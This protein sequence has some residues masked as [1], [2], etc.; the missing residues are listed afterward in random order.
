MSAL[1]RHGAYQSLSLLAVSRDAHFSQILAVEAYDFMPFPHPSATRALLL[2]LSIQ[3]SKSSEY[4]KALKP[5]VTEIKARYKGNE[6][7]QNRAVGK[8]YEDANQNPLSGCLLSLAQ[9]PIFL[10]LY[11]G[12]R[13]LALDGALEEPFLFIPSLEGPVSPPTYRGLDWLLQGWTSI[14]NMPTPQLGWETTLA[15]LTMP[16]LLVVLQSFTMS[17]LQPPVDQEATDEEKKQQETTQTVLK[18]LPLMIGFFSLQVP[19]GLTIYWLSSNLFTLTQSLAVKTYFAANPPE[20]ELPEYWDQMSEKKDFKD[21][22]PEERRKATE[23]GLSVGPSFED[24]VNESKFHVYVERQPFRETTEAWQRVESSGLSEIPLA[25][26]EWVA[27][28]A[29]TNGVD[30]NGIDPADEGEVTA[31][32][33]AESATVTAQSSQ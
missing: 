18:V 5:Y 10:G 2:P 32:D 20:I 25:M 30:A 7:A 23:A 3:Q 29:T 6:E 1:I 22:S 15:F 9:I 4:M 28:S 13:L 24:L 27:A 26:K 16:V 31:V 11:R 17:V 21:M 12:I 14:D 33:K 19:A 8:L